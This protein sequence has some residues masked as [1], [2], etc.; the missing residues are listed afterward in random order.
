MSDEMELPKEG[1]LAQLLAED[2]SL[3][4]QDELAQRLAVLEGEMA[5][6]KA[7]QE[8]KKGS[9]SEAEALFK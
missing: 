3:M 8:S 2:L 6:T 9:R 4:G 5:R 7:M 1:I